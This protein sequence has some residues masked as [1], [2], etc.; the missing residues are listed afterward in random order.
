MDKSEANQNVKDNS[1]G[2]RMIGGSVYIKSA[3]RLAHEGE[4][5]CHVHNSLGGE[6]TK[7]K[8]ILT[9]K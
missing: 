4:W 2:I 7:L 8:L 9:G 5:T 6:K 1:N 3:N